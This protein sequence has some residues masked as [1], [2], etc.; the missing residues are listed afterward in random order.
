MNSPSLPDDES[1]YND[2]IQ[3]HQPNHHRSAIFGYSPASQGDSRITTPSP[4]PAPE[5]NAATRETPGPCRFTG[6]QYR[7]MIETGILG[8]ENR[9]ELIQGEIKPKPPKSSEHSASIEQLHDW[10]HNR[11]ENNYR[12]RCQLTIHLGPD[13]SPDP[14]LA[15]VKRREDSAVGMDPQADDVLLIVEIAKTSLQQDL[16][17]KALDYARSHVPELWVVDTTLR[18]LHRLTNPSGQ[19]YLNREVFQTGET[20][21]PNLLRHLSMTINQ[22][23][24][25]EE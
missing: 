8:P 15:I 18:G 14:D 1:T 4:T 16:G 5:W 11:R 13:F 2:D 19:G 10:F 7:Q 6:Q 12:V 9:V 3:R 24:P 25:P 21:T 22:A 20:V 17:E 23:L